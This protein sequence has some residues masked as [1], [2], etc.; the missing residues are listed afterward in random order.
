MSTRT[1]RSR[2]PGTGLPVSSQKRRSCASAMAWNVPAVTD[3]LHAE[4]GEAGLELARG[5][6][7][8]RDREHVRAD[9]SR[10]R[11]PATRCDG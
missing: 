5:L 4:P 6:A 10:P 7:G 11:G 8:E 2:M 3:A 1:L 9:R